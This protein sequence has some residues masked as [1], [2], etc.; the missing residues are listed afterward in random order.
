MGMCSRS[1]Y[2]RILDRER[3][4]TSRPTGE[5]GQREG[6][7]SARRT[8]AR[9]TGIDHVSITTV[10][11][12]RS[13]A[14]YADLLDLRVM[15]RGESVDDKIG[16]MMDLKGVRIRWADVDLGEDMILELIQFIHPIGTLVEMSPWDPGATH[17][18]LQVDD[19]GGGSE[20]LHDAGVRIISR[21]V[22]LTEEGPWRGARV[23]YTIDPDGTWIELVERPDTVEISHGEGTVPRGT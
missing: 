11:L 6:L 4:W 17:I 12:D 2:G 7:V 18:G 14:F 5:P 10:D 20:R 21:P 15:A 13:I 9:V 22:Q 16:A 23:M 1:R 3:D 8:G 19:I